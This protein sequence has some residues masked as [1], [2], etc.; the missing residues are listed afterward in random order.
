[1]FTWNDERRAEDVCGDDDGARRGSGGDGAGDL[2]ASAVGRHLP[3]D[4]G[5]LHR[6]DLL[7][8]RHLPTVPGHHRANGKSSPTYITRQH[9][10]VKRLFC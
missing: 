6:S 7:P 5:R 10:L 1:M 8:G 9:Q 3:N 2:A 4:S